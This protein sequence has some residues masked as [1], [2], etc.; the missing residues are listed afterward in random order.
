QRDNWVEAEVP[1][2]V[3]EQMGW[4]VYPVRALDRDFHTLRTSDGGLWVHH[5]GECGK[6]RE[7]TLV[8]EHGYAVDKSGARVNSSQAIHRS[9]EELMDLAIVRP[10]T[11]HFMNPKEMLSEGL[12]A[13]RAGP[14]TRA[15]LLQ[16][17]PQLYEVVRQY[18]EKELARHFGT[19]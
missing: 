4:H 9:P 7:W 19:N 18:D 6:P 10:F 8:D 2:A 13:Y 17:S 1:A 5:S 16:A 14:E 11:Y 15:Q 12:T 3:A